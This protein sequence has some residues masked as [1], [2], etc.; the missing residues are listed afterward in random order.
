MKVSFG[1]VTKKWRAR[2]RS[3]LL[4][5]YWRRS[6][7]SIPP[8]LSRR[9]PYVQ[10]FKRRPFIFVIAQLIV[11]CLSRWFVAMPWVQHMDL[12][13][14]IINNNEH[15][16]LNVH[17][18]RTP[19]AAMLVSLH[20]LANRRWFEDARWKNLSEN[21]FVVYEKEER[22]KKRPWSQR[23]D[24]QMR[25][26]P[27]HRLTCIWKKYYAYLSN[28]K[29]NFENSNLWTIKWSAWFAVSTLPRHISTVVRLDRSLK[30]RNE[31]DFFL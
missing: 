31:S 23:P 27:Y 26:I 20:P 5:L 3:C 1:K 15:Y 18:I 17:S 16:P 12:L 22:S 6:F 2:Q 19:W 30:E 13:C 8:L 25:R 11:S 7:N 4:D 29:S 21:H 10:I 14:S 24:G 28:G 9:W